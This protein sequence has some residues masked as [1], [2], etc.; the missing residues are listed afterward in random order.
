LN[1]NTPMMAFIASDN[2]L[3]GSIPN[4]NRWTN[5]LEFSVASNS[6]TGSIPEFVMDLVYL[7]QL[8]IQDNLMSGS[9]PVDMCNA[10]SLNTFDF[11]NNL[12]K[13]YANCLISVPHL[14]NEQNISTCNHVQA[15]PI[16]Q[17]S[18]IFIIIGVACGGALLVIGLLYVFAREKIGWLL[19]EVHNFVVRMTEET[20]SL[21]DDL[22]FTS[23]RPSM[24]SGFQ[25]HESSGHRTM[26]TAAKDAEEARSMVGM[27][28][29]PVRVA[30]K[31]FGTVGKE[32]SERMSQFNE[33]L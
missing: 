30:A 6:L 5:L 17:D 16:S 21:L 29:A 32:K 25:H 14:I 24:V 9:I 19:G 33:N 7:Q 31:R 27:T 3:T 11:S 26:S 13:C 12:F 10:S 8:F 2:M 18:I 22:D 28:G 1:S 20:D 4:F 23:L 15:A